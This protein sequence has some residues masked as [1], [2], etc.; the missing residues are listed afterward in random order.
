MHQKKEPNYILIFTSLTL[1]IM[2]ASLPL[3]IPQH[4]FAKAVLFLC[5]Q[6]AYMGMIIVWGDSLRQRILNEKT[7]K[8]MTVITLLMLLWLLLRAI[9]HR[10]IGPF[11]VAERYVWYLYY[12]SMLLI[13][14]R[15]L[16]IAVEIAD[17]KNKRLIVRINRLVAYL[18]ILLVLSNDIHNLVF[19]IEGG[20]NDYSYGIGYYLVVV[21]IALNL[22]GGIIMLSL[23]NGHGMKS[24][25]RL[26]PLTWLVVLGAYTLL[27]IKRP[28]FLADFHLI[29]MPE[30]ICLI[31]LGIVESCIRS[32]LILTN[33]DY[34]AFFN[35]ISTPAMIADINGVPIF[36][37][38][39][40]VTADSEMLEAAKKSELFIDGDIKLFSENIRSGRIYWTVSYNEVKQLTGKLSDINDELTG[41]NELL[42]AEN[43]LRE[44]SLRVGE[45][46]SLYDE[47]DA[48]TV[49]QRGMIDGLLENLSENAPDYIDRLSMA[50]VINA[51]IKRRSNLVLLKNSN[52]RI[53][54]SEL[55]YSLRE[56]GEY[57]K[58]YGVY[59]DVNPV[60]G[61]SRHDA[62][63]ICLIYD[64]FEE[65]IEKNL[66]GLESML[67]NI[68][69]SQENL[70]IRFVLE[71]ETDICMPE[72]SASFIVSQR[73]DGSASYIVLSIGGETDA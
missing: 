9:K 43:K 50:C 29:E 72:T 42:S 25:K 34:P 31:F 30:A 66:S 37:S 40:P 54:L 44:E 22:L 23:V 15:F 51:Y 19:R 56:S 13:P 71:C 27:Y 59:F 3:R 12:L 2:L 10:F 45:Q 20:N 8:D 57:I 70:D 61:D 4:S 47:I 6:L 28:G 58:L 39:A 46:S 49:R 21:C 63:V 69:E 14:T 35:L 26:L 65:L 48:L 36:T 62:E 18:L 55:Y 32:G 68:K 73:A 11:E 7:K 33:T 38:A 64:Y 1:V 67:I 53:A 16:E 52:N 41:E 24:L 60:S 17:L 5:Q